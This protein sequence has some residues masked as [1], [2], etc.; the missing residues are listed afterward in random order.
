MDGRKVDISNFSY[1]AW[2][3]PFTIYTEDENGI[4]II[5]AGV[6]SHAEVKVFSNVQTI[7]LEFTNSSDMMNWRKDSVPNET[8]VKVKIAG[9]LP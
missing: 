7:S 3:L 9:L 2:K 5:A 1:K 6:S 4:K 8:P